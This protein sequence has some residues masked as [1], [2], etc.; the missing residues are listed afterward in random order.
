[1]TSNG[2]EETKRNLPN[3]N[4]IMKLNGMIYRLTPNGEK[5][6]LSDVTTTK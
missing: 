5:P 3:S 6:G 2:Y 4:N 1:M